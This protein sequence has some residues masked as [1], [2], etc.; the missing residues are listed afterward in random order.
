TF[1]ISLPPRVYQD[2]KRRVALFDDLVRKLNATP[3]ITSAAAMS[4]LPPRRNVDANDVTYEGYAPPPDAP[5]T[6][7]EFYQIVTPGYFT[8]MRIPIVSG[9]GFGPG[10]DAVSQPVAVINESLARVYYPNQNPIGRRV[11]QTGSKTFF[12]IIGVAKD[13]KQGGVD[14]KIGTELY[15]LY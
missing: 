5:P 7:A 3:G 9:R 6:N 1:S 10:D 4:G 13:V 12:T 8:A 15:F 2:N 14:S 11:Q